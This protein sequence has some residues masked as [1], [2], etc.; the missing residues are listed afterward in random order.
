MHAYENHLE[1]EWDTVFELIKDCHERIH[2][3]GAPRITA[4]LKLG[5][6]IDREQTME[7]KVQSVLDKLEKGIE[8]F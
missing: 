5:T 6:R 4:T 2:D 8:H 7:E 1:W 3:I